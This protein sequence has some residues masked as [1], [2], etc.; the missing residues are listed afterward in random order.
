MFKLVVLSCLLSV[1]FAGLI[2]H[3]P[4]VS[5]VAQVKTIVEPHL[6]VVETPTVN[7]VGSVVKNIPTGVSHHSSS[8]VHSAAP[9]VQPVYAHGVEKSVVSTPIVKNVVEHVPVAAPVVKVAYTQPIVAKAAYVQAPVAYSAPL[10]Y[11]APAAYS[12]PI[13]YAPKTV[14]YASYAPSYG[15]YPAAYSAHPVATSYSALPYS[16]HAW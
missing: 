16:H 5:H 1:A 11:A 10:A 12:A 3:E 7:H 13:A 15:S 2:H 14:S 9:I 4:V 6:S 8:V